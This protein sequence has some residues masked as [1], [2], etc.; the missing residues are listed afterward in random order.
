LKTGSSSTGS[1]VSGGR[2]LFQGKKR[3][4]EAKCFGFILLMHCVKNRHSRLPGIVVLYNVLKK[5]IP[6]KPE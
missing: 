3:K 6:D 1:T 2:K 5:Q 4:A